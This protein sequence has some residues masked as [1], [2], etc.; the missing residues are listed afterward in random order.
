GGLVDMREVGAVPV[1]RELRP[2]G[3]GDVVAG[4]LGALPGSRVVVGD[5][6]QARPLPWRQLVGEQ[7]VEPRPAVG[8]EAPPEVAEGEVR[9]GGIVCVQERQELR[10]ELTRPGV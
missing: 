7:L 10:L 1:R 9:A 3:A 5:E 4:G 8:A 2:E 6:Q